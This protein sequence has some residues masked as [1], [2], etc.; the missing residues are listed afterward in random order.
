MTQI[1]RRNVLEAM[2]LSAGVALLGRSPAS[3]MESSELAPT[4]TSTPSTQSGSFGPLKEVDAGDLRVG[5][6]E[7]GPSNG[8]RSSFCMAGR[9]ISKLCEVTPQLASAGYRVIVPYLRG[10]GS[11]CSSFRQNIPQRTTFGGCCG[12]YCADGRAQ[13]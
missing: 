3:A 10:Y 2:C 12:Y 1:S 9:T 8:R 4:T 7:Q 13:D 6:V 11:T 5:Y